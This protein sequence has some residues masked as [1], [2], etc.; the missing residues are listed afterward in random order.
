M[1]DGA[2]PASHGRSAPFFAAIA[3]LAWS[4]TYIVTSELLPPDRPFFGAVARVLPVAALFLLWKRRLP[5][6]WWW[7]KSAV[8]GLLNFG[9]FFALLYVGAYRLPGGLAATLQSL[10]PL[11]MIGLAAVLLA[12]RPRP[13]TV[14]AAVAGAA[15]VA[16][17]LWNGEGSIDPLGVLAALGSVLS[18][19]AGYVLVRKWRPPVDMVTFT[20]WQLLLSGLMLAPLAWL[21]EGP[22]PAIEAPALLGYVYLA[23][24]GT[25][26]AYVLWFRG[27]QAAPAGLI[28][29]IGLLNP[30]S[31]TI[32]GIAVR[33]EAFGW[34][35]ALGMALVL[36]GVLAS[37]LAA[38]RADRREREGEGEGPRG[39][40][41][42]DPDAPT[43]RAT[44]GAPATP[45]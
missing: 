45:Q 27:L 10:G 25:A 44:G 43:G 24:V 12:E 40:G 37:Q 29:V 38:R 36:G 13:T 39:G 5:S 16:I 35:Q 34:P 7:W 19:S 32:I 6:G 20:G 31:A 18:A 3:P 22:P 42:D 1:T 41:A 23:L 17:M 9:F 26:L 33:H 28:G 21:V 14:L 4:T 15:G 2:P 11:V 8:L 30:V